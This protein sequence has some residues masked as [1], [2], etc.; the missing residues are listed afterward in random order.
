MLLR[1][2]DNSNL[3]SRPCFQN[4]YRDPPFCTDPRGA[5][6][7]RVVLYYVSVPPCDFTLLTMPLNALQH[8]ESHSNTRNRTPTLGI[9]LQNSKLHLNTRNHTPNIRNRASTFEITLQHS[10]SHSNTRN[11][12]ST[13]E[14]ACHAITQFQAMWIFYPH[15]TGEAITQFQRPLHTRNRTA[16]LGI[17][18]PIFEIGE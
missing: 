12:A 18:P 9:A 1:I 4:R 7:L 8:S 11:R 15:P 13:F 3:T 14:I 17:T 2:E 10:K 16:T 5:S 6:G